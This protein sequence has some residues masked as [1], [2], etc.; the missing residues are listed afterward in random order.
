M[1]DMT[2]EDVRTLVGQAP[3]LC[4]IGCNDGTDT[5]KFLEAM[6]GAII[7]CFEC[8]PRAIKRFKRNVVS[9]RVVLYDMAISD[10]DGE[11]TFHG[12]S[13]RAPREMLHE[14]IPACHLLD[15]WD[16]SGSLL[17][18]SRHRTYSKWVEFPEEQQRIVQT[19]RLDTWATKHLAD[20]TIDFCWVDVQGG[21]GLV[22]KGGIETLK[23]TR[24]LYTETY[25]NPLYAGQPTT[26][27]L[28]ALIAEL[29]PDYKFVKQYSDNILLRNGALA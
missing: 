11:A 26:T 9:R 15:S 19:I 2:V 1:A 18:P 7:H 5:L 28:V 3:L 20:R 10:T 12:S 22:I 23:R 24:W 21:E 25:E 4:E 27:E 16:L 8:D 13:G 6:P 17:E 14:P 29:L